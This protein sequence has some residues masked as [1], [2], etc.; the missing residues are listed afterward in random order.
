VAIILKSKPGLS[1]TT[2]LNI[3]AAWD[4]TWFRNLISNQ[5]KGAD[6]RNAISGPGISR[7]GNISSPYATISIGGAGPITLPG[8][9]TVTGGG[10]IIGAPTGG[11][12]GAGTVNAMSYYL[13]GVL[14]FQ[15]GT[16]TGTLT[17]FSG[18]APSG[19][20]HYTIA[21]GI[22]TI[23]LANSANVTGTSNATTMTLTGLPAACQPATQYP[24]VP[25]FLE[26]ATAGVFGAAAM[27]PG[28]GTV[29]F[30]RSV[31]SGTAVQLSST[32]FTASGTKG[33]N[34]TVLTY[35]LQ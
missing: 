7:T 13:N 8:P 12:E 25:V 4:A 10:L 24:V 6:V 28:S 23:S 14:L 11:N 2:T 5:L 34:S 18:T 35:S 16:F 20:F 27:T 9:V 15:A 22:C 19:T 3:P 33:M 29:S 1:S 17:G 32:G 30:Y 26:D 21:N 31:V